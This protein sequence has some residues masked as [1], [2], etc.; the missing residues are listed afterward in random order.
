MTSESNRVRQQK[1]IRASAGGGRPR[2]VAGQTPIQRQ[3][4]VTSGRDYSP[5]WLRIPAGY[6]WR[7]IVIGAGLYFVAVIA[8]R[9]QLVFVALFL[10]I[11]LTAILRP[12]T[13]S[14]ARFMPRPLAVVASMLIAVAVIAALVAFISVSVVGQWDDLSTKFTDGIDSIITLLKDQSWTDRLPFKLDLNNLSAQLQSGLSAA[15]DWVQAN[16]SD[17]ASQVIAGAGAVVEVFTGLALGIFCSVFFINSGGTMW[18]WFLDQVPDKARGK[19]SDAGDAAWET[20]SGYTR[21]IFLVAATNGLFAGIA[22]TILQ[23]PLSAPLG[24]L[25]FIGTFIPLIGS[26][27]AMMVAVVVALAANGPLTA[28]LVLALIV[29]IGQFEGNVLQ[30]LIMG[31]QVSIHPVAVAL[32]VAAGTITAG[33]VGAIVAV[34]VVSV[35]WAVFS[36]LRDKQPPPEVEEPKRHRLKEWLDRRRARSALNETDA[37]IPVA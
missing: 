10:A 26:P 24:V 17:L 32:S 33:V 25:V 14:L 28:V 5:R 2:T 1:R 8:G 18:N 3:A 27:I 7:I 9:L 16:W 30:P 35:A 36:R 31:R 4:A 11:V 37:D 13:N 23:V 22:L 15:T 21:A 29:L 20:F 12:L 19:W 34:P 6:A